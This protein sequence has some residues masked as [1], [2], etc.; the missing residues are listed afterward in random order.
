MLAAKGL[1]VLPADDAL[2]AAVGLTFDDGVVVAGAP[3]VVVLGFSE[4]R[5]AE[6]SSSSADRTGAVTVAVVADP[7]RPTPVRA[8]G[9]LPTLTRAL[10]EPPPRASAGA[11]VRTP[12]RRG[13]VAACPGVDC[14]LCS[15]AM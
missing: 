8:T 9:A 10:P 6:Y 15:C 1:V 12:L 11:P 7:L 13:A 2:A 14:E 4:F 5:S 3:T